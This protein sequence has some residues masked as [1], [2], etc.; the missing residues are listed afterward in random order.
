MLRGAEVHWQRSR[1]E[2]DRS[3]STEIAVLRTLKLR[4]SPKYTAV[5]GGT[6]GQAGCRGK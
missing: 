6:Q 2:R 5:G 1:R 4:E 3:G